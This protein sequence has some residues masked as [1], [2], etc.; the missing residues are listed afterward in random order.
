MGNSIREAEMAHHT[1]IF[2]TRRG[3]SDVCFGLI[4]LQYLLFWALI[5][6]LRW[7]QASSVKNVSFGSRTP[8]CTACKNQLQQCVLL[9]QSS[10]SITWIY[11]ILYGRRCK[12]LLALQAVVFETCACWANRA[13]DLRGKCSN[14]APVS[15]SVSSVSK[16]FCLVYFLSKKDPVERTFFYQS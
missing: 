11:V 15:S 3:T 9:P 2:W 4:L 13:R 16:A 7:N 12:F 10:S 6:P 5:Y 1:P 14:L 8:S